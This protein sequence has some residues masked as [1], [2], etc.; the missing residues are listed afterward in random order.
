MIPCQPAYVPVLLLPPHGLP[1]LVG[2]ARGGRA[3]DAPPDHGSPQHDTRV[4][5][6]VLQLDIGFALLVSVV[7]VSLHPTTEVI[8]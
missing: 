5:D 2:A 3:G 1:L 6:V 4:V 7:F 8:N